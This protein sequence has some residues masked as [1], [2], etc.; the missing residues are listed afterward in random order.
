[1]GE[2]VR[3]LIAEGGNMYSRLLLLIFFLLPFMGEMLD[4]AEGA[5]QWGRGRYTSTII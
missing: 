3:R 1:M 2:R 4:R 5:Q